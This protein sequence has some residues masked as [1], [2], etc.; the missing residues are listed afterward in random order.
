MGRIAAAS[1]GFTYM[2]SVTGVTGERAQMESRVAGW[3]A[4]QDGA[5]RWRGFGI[6]GLQQA[7][8]VRS[9]GRRPLLQCLG[10][11]G[12]AKAEGGDPWL[13][14]PSAE[15]RAALDS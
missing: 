12:Q 10:R 3:W 9:W 15:L 6:S 1:R 8:E 14:E 7:I 4:S 13:A 2:V 5:S 11:H